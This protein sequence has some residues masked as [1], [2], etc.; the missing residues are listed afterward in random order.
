M[1][2]KETVTVSVVQM[3]C[4]AVKLSHTRERRMKAKVNRRTVDLSAYPDLVVSLSGHAG[5]C[6]SPASR[7]WRALARGSPRGWVDARPD[8]LLLHETL[9]FRSCRRMSGCAE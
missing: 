3:T 8:G 5:Q 9:L 1:T 2:V 4:S 7:R 6:A